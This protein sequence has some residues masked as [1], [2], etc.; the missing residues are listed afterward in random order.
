MIVN[1][2]PNAEVSTG[3][4]PVKAGTYPM[5]IV[6]V[7]DRYSDGKN[8]LKVTLEHITQ[9]DQLLGV[10]N[11]ELKGQ[12]ARVFDYVMLDPEKQWKLRSITESAGLPWEDYDP[13]V[14]LKG[15][16]VEVILKLETYEGNQSNKVNRYVVPQA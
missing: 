4:S 15:K 11:A 16:E 2:N 7:V 14:D 6:D 1:V 10:D 12:P 13:V 9:A 3:F 5:R 8:D